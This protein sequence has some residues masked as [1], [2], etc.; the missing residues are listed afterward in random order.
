VGCDIT[1]NW[2]NWPI[3][4]SDE[5]CKKRLII[6]LD[7]FFDILTYVMVILP[8]SHSWAEI[9]PLIGLIGQLTN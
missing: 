4:Q 6:I 8:V 2:L 3:N 7:L 1:A 9:L 5:N